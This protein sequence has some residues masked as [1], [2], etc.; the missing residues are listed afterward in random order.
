MRLT[1]MNKS[2]D[3]EQHCLKVFIE[4]I[5]NEYTETVTDTLILRSSAGLAVPVKS[6]QNTLIIVFLAKYDRLCCPNSVNDVII[7]YCSSNKF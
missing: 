7:P 5:E 3:I 1:F 2:W 6:R 4:F